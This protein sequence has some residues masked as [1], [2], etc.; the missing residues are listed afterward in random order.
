MTKIISGKNFRDR[1]KEELKKYDFSKHRLLIFQ[2]G[3]NDAS[4]LYI[5][6]KVN[7][8]NEIG[9]NTTTFFLPYDTTTETLIVEL[10]KSIQRFKSKGEKVGFLIQQPLPKHID[11]DT[12]FALDDKEILSADIECV[13]DKKMIELWNAKTK[14][15]EPKILPCTPKGIIDL[16]DDFAKENDLGDL[17]TGK[18]YLVIG[19]SKI[20]GLPLS[21][22]LQHR[23]ATV[24]LAHSKTT[25]LNELCEISD[26]IIPCVGKKDL[27]KNAKEGSIVMD[28]GISYD[29]NGKLNGDLSKELIE[30]DKLLAYTPTPG[31]TGPVTVFEIFENLKQ[32]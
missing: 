17:Y 22:M 19:R 21:Q 25:N 9:A 26:V 4:D 27:I 20:L 31:G 14:D 18:T 5:K 10:K 15:D 2:V 6:N 30:S 1:K 32:L 24:I 12:V 16:L 11:L 23:N 8:A 3:D 7:F 28:A 13:F 29:E